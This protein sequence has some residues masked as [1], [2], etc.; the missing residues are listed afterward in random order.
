MSIQF[1]QP[2]NEE[3]LAAM[4][5]AFGEP[6]ARDD[7]VLLYDKLPLPLIG[8]ALSSIARAAGQPV[9]V[10]MGGKGEVKTLADGTQYRSTPRGWKKIGI[11][12]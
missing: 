8:S 10:E 6:T 1:E 4:R 7:K 11:E 3:A 12:P 5:E 9:I 2:Y